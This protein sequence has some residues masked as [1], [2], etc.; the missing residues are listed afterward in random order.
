MTVFKI[1]V[2]IL[3]MYLKYYFK[4]MYFK[5]L[6]ITAP[7]PWEAGNANDPT[8]TFHIPRAVVLVKQLMGVCPTFDGQTKDER[9]V[10]VVVTEYLYGR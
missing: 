2:K 10:V 7:V 3:G 1:H 9:V 4:Y 8:V 5:I 6:P